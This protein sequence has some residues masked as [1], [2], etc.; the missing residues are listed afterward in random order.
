MS[1]LLFHRASTRA[2]VDIGH[3]DSNEKAAEIKE[4]LRRATTPPRLGYAGQVDKV[5]ELP[6][7]SGATAAGPSTPKESDQGCQ[8]QRLSSP[9][10]VPPEEERPGASGGQRAEDAE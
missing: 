3:R 1:Y 2:L 7:L 4:F 8:A 6:D 9:H 10:D 5:R